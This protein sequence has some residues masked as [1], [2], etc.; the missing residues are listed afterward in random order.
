MLKNL[1]LFRL[2]ILNLAGFA[3]AAWAWQL[4][5]IEAVY[6]GDES[7]ITLVITT[8]FAGGLASAWVRA[9][10]VSRLLD[11]SKENRALVV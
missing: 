3:V 10:K 5:Y 9:Q 7:R 1:L 4:G 2:A 11:L 6:A 8:L